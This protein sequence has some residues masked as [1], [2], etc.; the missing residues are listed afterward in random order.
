MTK[1]TAIKI[2]MMSPIYFRL[3]IR[4]RMELIEEF[5]RLNSSILNINQLN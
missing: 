3:D 5:L 2:L 4:Q 1:R